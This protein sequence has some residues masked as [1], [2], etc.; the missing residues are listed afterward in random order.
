M[1]WLAAGM[2]GTTDGKKASPWHQMLSRTCWRVRNG[3][4]D[5]PRHVISTSDSSSSPSLLTRYLINNR[6]VTLPSLIRK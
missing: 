1:R 3:R 2:S 6:T 4:S 5:R